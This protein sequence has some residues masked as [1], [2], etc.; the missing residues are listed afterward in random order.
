MK[1]FMLHHSKSAFLDNRDAMQLLRQ[2][3]VTNVKIVKGVELV[4][5]M[6]DEDALM[7]ELKGGVN[8]FWR[9]LREQNWYWGQAGLVECNI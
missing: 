5:K 9:L 8:E 4:A 6:S 2:M 3:G 7:F 1:Q